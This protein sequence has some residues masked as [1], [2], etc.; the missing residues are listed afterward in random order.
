M[1]NQTSSSSFQLSDW[2]ED[3]PIISTIYEDKDYFL[4]LTLCVISPSPLLILQINTNIAIT[5]HYLQKL[6]IFKI[7]FQ[8]IPI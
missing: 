7:H 5:S 2:T 1:T 6:M 4:F 3:M 8:N